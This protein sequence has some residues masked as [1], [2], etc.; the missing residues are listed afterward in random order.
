[1]GL[2]GP[3]GSLN[4]FLC[5]KEASSLETII[6]VEGSSATL[7]IRTDLEGPRG[8]A[9]RNLVAL[10][11]VLQLIFRLLLSQVESFLPYQVILGTKALKVIPKSRSGYYF[12]AF[13]GLSS[14]MMSLNSSSPMSPLSSQSRYL[15]IIFASSFVMESI[16]SFDSPFKNYYSLILPFAFNSKLL[17]ASLILLLNFNSKNPCK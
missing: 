8:L 15:N 16:P 6:G 11:S 7:G 2:N 14:C 13:G 5:L 4:F 10:D 3:I 1:M 17:N 12:S 9:G